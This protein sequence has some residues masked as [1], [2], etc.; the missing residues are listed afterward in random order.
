MAVIVLNFAA[1]QID[2]IAR[3]FEPLGGAHDPDIVPHHA[4]DFGP[5]LLDDDLFIRVR[6]AAFVPFAHGG[7]SFEI[8]PMRENVLRRRFAEHE[9]FEQAI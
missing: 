2:A 7:R 4:A 5:V 6:H 9:A 3:A 8:V 1:Q